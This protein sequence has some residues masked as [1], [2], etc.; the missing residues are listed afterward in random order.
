[1]ETQVENPAKRQVSPTLALILIL[2][3][4]NVSSSFLQEWLPKHWAA[5]IPFFVLM[6]VAYPVRERDFNTNFV[7]WCLKALLF[8]VML[9]LT[10][11]L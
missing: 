7:R 9:T 3:V 1:M 2:L 4:F 5:G 8:A 11:A 10:I 6:V